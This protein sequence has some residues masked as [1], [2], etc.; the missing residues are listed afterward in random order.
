MGLEHDEQYDPVLYDDGDRGEQDDGY[1]QH[2]WLP[3]WLVDGLNVLFD[4]VSEAFDLWFYV[5]GKVG[6]RVRPPRAC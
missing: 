1:W 6:E 3:Q 2:E 4:Q 5:S